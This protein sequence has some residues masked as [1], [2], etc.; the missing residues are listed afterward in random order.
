MSNF[1]RLFGPLTA[2]SLLI[3]LLVLSA[4]PA[5]AQD[6]DEEEPPPITPVVLVNVMTNAERENAKD[7]D[8]RVR[9]SLRPLSKCTPTVGHGTYDTPWIQARTGAVAKLSLQE[10][11]YRISAVV[12]DASIEGGCSYPPQ[13]AWGREPSDADYVDDSL[14]SFSRPANE[15]TL[16]I[17]RKPDSP[18]LQQNR[19]YFIIRGG[20]LVAALPGA[21]ADAELLAAARRAA[22]LSE[23]TVR[24]E[25]DP[26]TGTAPVPGCDRTS[27]FTVR[28]DVQPV[29]VV[30]HNATGE[31]PLRASVVDA[32]PAFRVFDER[33]VSFDGAGLNI[34]VDLSYLLGLTPARIVII[35]D[36][37]GSQNRGAVSYA[38]TRSCGG[39]S[40]SAPAAGG[41]TSPLV[42]GRYTVHGS[43]VPAFGATA[44]Y[45]VGASSSASSV[46]GCSVTVT[47]S[48]LPGTCSVAGGGTQTLTWS[49]TDPIEHFDFEFD[50]GCG[51]A[52]P[53]TAS[54]PTP[55][56]G[57]DDQPTQEPSGDG[58]VD[59]GLG[60]VRIVARKLANGKIEFG[61]QQRQDDTSWGGRLLPS[62][63]LFPPDAEVGE[64]LV[65]S[66]L[67]V[68][69][70]ESA[71]A[72]AEDVELRIVARLASDGRVEFGLQQRPDGGVW[73]ERQAPVRRY[74]PADARSDR[75]LHSSVV[76]LTL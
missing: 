42:E 19:T 39:A 41:A 9:V 66:P 23:F 15:S 25:P 55:P 59:S 45:A 38:V 57:T 11:V 7:E 8:W 70:G 75:W 18:C 21:S 36:V 29:P 44:T 61:L 53:P 32:P 68:A 10:C 60:D 62:A 34:L 43:H 2:L 63:R 24:V 26:P 76:V 30:L 40:T 73:G 22:A 3:P 20:D 52:V 6:D 65:S 51:G 37:R 69:V 74:F 16:S 58:V 33:S 12:R 50:I 14:L 35:Q 54:E 64:W 56:S 49:A 17:R 13:L 72:L 47:M 4:A 28:G 1:R 71:D 5:A 48:G 31:C 27:E 67:T 46:S